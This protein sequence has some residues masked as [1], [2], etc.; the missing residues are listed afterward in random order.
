MYNPLTIAIVIVE[1]IQGGMKTILHV[2]DT[3]GPG[4][5]ET[6]FIQLAD[7][8]RQR[9]YRSLVLIRGPGWVEQELRRRGLEPIILEAKGSFNRAFLAG[10]IGLIRREKVDLIQSHLLGSNVYCALAGLLT[11]RPV[12][13]TFHGAVD[14]NPNE[15]F[16]RLKYGLLNAGVKQFIAVS[17]G[18]QD[19]IAEAGLLNLHKTRVIYNGIDIDRY[20]R[21]PSQPIRQQL[22][23]DQQAFLVGSLGNVRPAKA[24]DI[25]IRAAAE[26]ADHLHFVIAGDIKQRLM[27]PLQALMEE[28]G[29]Q[30]RVHF[31]GYCDDSA[32]FLGQMDAFLLCS[33]SEGFS[34]STIEAMASGLPVLATR[35]G[36]PE[37][38]L[39]NGNDG[40][41]V[42][43]EDYRALAAQ[44]QQWSEQPASAATLTEQAVLA[45]A[46]RF[47][48]EAMLDQYGAIYEAL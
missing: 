42:N 45:A 25:L 12:V 20:Y 17:R 43:N 14:I 46:E 29:V 36:G 23:L 40:I 31:I 44:L 13:A 6:V 9:G 27:P 21:R 33:R 35:C 18:L 2:I 16:R 28:L 3:T 10:L 30:Q 38:I 39:S 5:A 37:E 48:L 24:Y 19:F 7:H 34:I 11:R 26:T 41:L 22:G 32:D 1:G 15:R 4:G 8:L 47:S